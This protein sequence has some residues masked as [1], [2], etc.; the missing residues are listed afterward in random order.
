M[1]WLP[2]P[3]Y[4]DRN[5]IATAVADKFAEFQRLRAISRFAP[6]V[7][8]RKTDLEILCKIFIGEETRTA[9]INVQQRSALRTEVLFLVGQLVGSLHGG[10]W[11][12]FI[13]AAIYGGFV[14]RFLLLVT[15]RFAPAF[16]FS[17]RVVLQTA[18]R[19]AL[20]QASR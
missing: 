18:R 6:A 9:P 4:R 1:I 14:M 15:R 8:R 13:E 20:L 7:D 16:F 17:E 19:A 12:Y 10:F 11:L 2:L 3:G 5:H